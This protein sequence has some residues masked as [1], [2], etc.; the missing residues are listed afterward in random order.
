MEAGAGSKKR[1]VSWSVYL[2]SH[3]SSLEHIQRAA[4]GITL[5]SCLDVSV[6]LLLDSPKVG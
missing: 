4:A 2:N 1:G 5:Q 3:S 6:N